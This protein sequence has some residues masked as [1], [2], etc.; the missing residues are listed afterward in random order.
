[1]RQSG[2]EFSAAE[3]DELF[4]KLDKDNN[5][6]IDY[7]EF[8]NGAFELSLAFNEQ[9]LRRVFNSLDADRNGFLEKRELM[10]CVQGNP[11]VE[12]TIG[13]MLSQADANDDSKATRSLIP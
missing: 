13:A 3:V 11:E 8:M 9:M 2:C 10:H 5:G 7:S 1:M 12:G 4:K 6:V